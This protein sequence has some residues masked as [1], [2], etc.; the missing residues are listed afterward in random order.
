MR[1]FKLD[2]Y[3]GKKVLITGHTGFKGTWMCKML[4]RAG[5]I[6]VGYSLEPPTKP[7]LFE[8]SEI[9]K[10][11]ESIIGDIRDYEKLKKEVANGCASV[12]RFG[13][14]IDGREKQPYFHT[15][16]MENG[17]AKEL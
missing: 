13:V 10:G 17:E 3:K 4:I 7:S 12:P 9:E 1:E 6:V 5:A 11:M 2:F 16:M 15:G 8:I 14:G